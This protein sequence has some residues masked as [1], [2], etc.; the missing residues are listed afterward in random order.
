MISQEAE[1]L[2][3][4]EANLSQ[5]VA[6][7]QEKKT[8]TETLLAAKNDELK[9]QEKELSKTQTLLEQ[10]EAQL[11]QQTAII[12]SLEAQQKENLSKQDAAIA[13]LA[14][15]VKN[16]GEADKDQAEKDV[17]LAV[18]KKLAELQQDVDNS[19]SGNGSYNIK[20]DPNTLF[21]WPCPSSTRITSA[22][23]SRLHPVYGEYRFHNGID[24]GAAM[25]EGIIATYQGTVISA[26]Y[27]SSMGN[28]VM[29]DH[30]QGLTSIYMHA[31]H[32]YVSSG[33]KVKTG[34]VIA[35]VGST[36]VS[37][38]PHLHFSIRLN[39]EYQNP[40]NYVSR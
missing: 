21:V 6:D 32:L 3:L 4:E 37:T 19:M 12:A 15:A 25:G 17:A 16:A 34:Q 13:A 33:D 20:V 27:N 31:S 2:A 30:G 28:Y 8:E 38:G 29:I 11:E 40:L 23:G 18:L 5:L 14:A 24:V 26:G 22:Y 7:A 1:R 39:G 10:Y 35:L 9:L 36:G